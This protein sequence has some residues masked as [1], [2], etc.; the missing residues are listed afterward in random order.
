MI[1]QVGAFIYNRTHQPDDSFIHK[2]G[3]LCTCENILYGALFLVFEL[4]AN[5]TSNCIGPF[6]W[7][8][9]GMA[10]KIKWFHGL[11]KKNVC[12]KTFWNNILLSVMG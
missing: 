1:E 9:Y 3:V 8:S 6:C 4:D 11:Y 2:K 5:I 7:N 10:E 12:K